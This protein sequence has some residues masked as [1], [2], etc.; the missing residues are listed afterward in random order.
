MKHRDEILRG[1]KTA[2]TADVRIGQSGG[3]KQLFGGVNPYFREISV[4]CDAVKRAEQTAEMR[5]TE[6]ERICNVFVF[7]RL[8]VMR[9]HIL[10]CVVHPTVKGCKMRRVDGGIL[11]Y[12]MQ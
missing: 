2:E 8:L 11:G 5:F 7:D 10:L 9:L 12:E 3:R 1:T 4:R 6:I